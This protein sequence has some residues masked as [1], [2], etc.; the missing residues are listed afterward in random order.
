MAA[1]ARTHRGAALLVAA[2]LLAQTI[3]MG[4]AVAALDVA[5]LVS[6][7]LW[8]AR[9]VPA[10]PRRVL[11]AL[12]AAVLVQLAHLAEEY[13]AGFQRAFPA[14]LG[15]AWSDAR[16]LGFNAAW[17]AVFA[18]SALLVARGRRLG[19]LGATFLAVGGGIGN[20][21]GHLALV[22]RAGGYFPGAYTAP[23]ALGAGALLLAQLLRKS[24]HAAAADA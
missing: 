14:L 3:V 16:F 13:H 20:G 4:P 1:L 24:P 15:Y 10:P 19:Y 21:L 9:P 17:L 2:A 11:L 8:A 7:A 22:A 5:L 6:Y 12:G 23:L 18:A